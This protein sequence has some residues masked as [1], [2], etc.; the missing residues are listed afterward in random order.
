MFFETIANIINALLRL[1]NIDANPVVAGAVDATD[2][3]GGVVSGSSSPPVTA[4]SGRPLH[5]SMV[6]IPENIT[7]R[8]ADTGS[9][10]WT[11]QQGP[12][13]IG[14]HYGTDFGA[15]D[16]SVVYAPYDFTVS[17]IGHY[18]DAG[19]YGDYVIGSLGSGGEYYSGHLKDVSVTAGQF[20]KS[21]EPI[22]KT[23]YLNH[24]HVQLRIGGVLSDFEEYQKTH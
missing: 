3:I 13:G 21:G 5:R 9:P 18:D 23:N 2:R 24:T 16:G 11:N 6:T 12:L 7:A 19:R 20:I 4:P 1:L 8:F 10:A 22:G 15:P 17:K 14:H